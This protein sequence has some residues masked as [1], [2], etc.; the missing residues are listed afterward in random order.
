[1]S[2][3]L[4]ESCGSIIVL[5]WYSQVC[6]TRRQFIEGA[7]KNTKSQKEILKPMLDVYEKEQPVWL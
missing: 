7:Q 6:F 2:R 1:M 5:L 4:A 3:F